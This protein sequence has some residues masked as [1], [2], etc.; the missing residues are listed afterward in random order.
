ML[1]GLAA[2]WYALGSYDH[3]VQRIC[4]ASDLSPNDENPYLF[5]GKMQ[6]VEAAPSEA[7]IE[8][9][10]RFVRLQP[11]NAL[12]SYY[13]AVSVWKRRRKSPEDGKNVAEVEA[14]LEKAIQLD[15]TLGLAHL[16]LGILYSERKEFSNAVAAYQRAIQAT[17]SLEEAHYRLA[18]A[19]RQTGETSKAQAELKLYEE[20]SNEKAAE[21]ERQRHE[22]QQFVYQLR[23]P[24]TSSKPN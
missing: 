15:P 17:P 11:G 12:A 18:Q 13:Y 4:E 21:I 7:I 19:Y 3:A 2:S 8:R 10:E 9:L 23:E 16:Q 24:A 5:M 22:V 6:D 1:E 14:L 20:I